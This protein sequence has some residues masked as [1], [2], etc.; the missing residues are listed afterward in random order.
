MVGFP[1]DCRRVRSGTVIDMIIAF[2]RL[3]TA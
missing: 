2:M 3:R 1:D